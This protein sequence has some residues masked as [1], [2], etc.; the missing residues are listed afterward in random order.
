MGNRKVRRN[1]NRP[2]SQPQL[3]SLF[4]PDYDDPF[5]LELGHEQVQ[6]ATKGTCQSPRIVF[7]ISFYETLPRQEADFALAKLDVCQP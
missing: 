5:G 6:K 2:P 4:S 3:R 1:S 7:L